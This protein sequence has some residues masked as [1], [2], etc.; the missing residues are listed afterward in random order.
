MLTITQMRR[1]TGVS[2]RTLQDYDHLGLLKHRDTT[3]GGYWLYAEEDVERLSVI[4]MLHHFGYTRKEIREV[5]DDP[6]ISLVQLLDRAQASLERKRD[7]LSGLLNHI[8]FIRL[9]QELPPI[10]IRAINQR[11][12]ACSPMPLMDALETLTGS[13]ANSDLMEEAPE[14]LPLLTHISCLLLLDQEPPDSP[15]VALCVE[16]LLRLVPAA[17]ECAPECA[18]DNMQ[19]FLRELAEDNPQMADRCACA[20]ETIRRHANGL[21]GAGADGKAG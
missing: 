3:P 1:L 11:S 7:H 9:Q 12:T 14:L 17:L 2:R 6:D 10:T 8:R 4:Q 15:A 16:S 20:A 13:M 5:I 19:H 18:A 21:P